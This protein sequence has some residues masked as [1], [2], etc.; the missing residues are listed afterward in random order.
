MKKNK[1]AAAKAKKAL[2]SVRDKMIAD[3]AYDGRFR[4]NTFTDKKKELNKNFCKSYNYE[5]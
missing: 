1:A 5:I 3:G 4:G 2:A